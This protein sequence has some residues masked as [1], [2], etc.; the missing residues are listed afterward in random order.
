[1][2]RNSYEAAKLGD[3]EIIIRESN[4]ALQTSF[5]LPQSG[6]LLLTNKRLVFLPTGLF[7]FYKA[8]PVIISIANIGVAAIKRGDISNLLAGSLRK[9]LSVR[10]EG[11]EYIFLVGKLEHWVRAVQGAIQTQA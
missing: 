1:M 9:R 2:G 3:G 8:K 4:A 7:A 10:C 6:K 5:F 11:E